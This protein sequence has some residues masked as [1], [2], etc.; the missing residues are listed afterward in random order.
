M[1]TDYK[2]QSRP[3][4]FFRAFSRSSRISSIQQ[5]REPF[6]GKIFRQKEVL[7]FCIQIIKISPG[8][9][10]FSGPFQ[11]LQEYRQCEQNREPFSGKIFRQKEVLC[12]CIQI[13]KISPGLMRFSGPFQGLQEYRQCAR[14]LQTDGSFPEKLRLLLTV[15]RSSGGEYDLPDEEPLF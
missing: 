11:G 8:L 10:R 7:C 1:Y 5:N 13:I 6:S 2:D 3:Y 14:F 4:A 9:M 15:R 12:F